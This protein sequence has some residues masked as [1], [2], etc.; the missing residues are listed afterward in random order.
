MRQCFN[1]RTRQKAGLATFLYIL[2]FQMAV[3]E[4][5]GS[6]INAFNLLLISISNFDFSLLFQD[7]SF[8]L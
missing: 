1:T 8:I 2:Y 6:A 4:L 5:N 3:R 7:M